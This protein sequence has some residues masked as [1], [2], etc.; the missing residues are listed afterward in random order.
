[1]AFTPPAAEAEAAEAHSPSS[2]DTPSSYSGQQGRTVLFN[3]NASGLVFSDLP[4]LGALSGRSFVTGATGIAATG[5]SA[6]ALLK[7]GTAISEIQF[8]AGEAAAS[9]SVAAAV[10]FAAGDIF[11]IAAP[12]P[13]DAMLA[14]IAF[15]LVFGFV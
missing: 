9:F 14:D 3:A 6:F 12:D 4:N 1:M 8:A 13:Q 11:A 5:P 2:P 15:T 7:N 10:D